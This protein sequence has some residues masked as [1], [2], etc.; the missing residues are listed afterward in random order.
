MTVFVD[1]SA[2]YG[3]LAADDAR[4]AAAAGT[5]ADLLESRTPLRTHTY[6]LVETVALVQR[7]LGLAAV[8]DLHYQLLPQM[9]VRPVDAGLHSTAMTALLAADRRSVSLVDWVSFVMMREESL[10]EAFA[11]DADFAAEGFRLIPGPGA[12]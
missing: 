8:A 9:S 4:H 3:G 5:W 12:R 1:T 6:V 7:R 11:F 10:E 2:L